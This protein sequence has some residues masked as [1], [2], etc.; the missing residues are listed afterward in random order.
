MEAGGS[1]FRNGRNVGDVMWAMGL[2]WEDTVGPMLDESEH[3]PVERA[4]ELVSV[5][6]ARPFTKEYLT[7]FYL[8]HMTGDTDPH[9][10]QR[11]AQRLLFGHVPAI[12][13]VSFEVWAPTVQ[14]KREMLLAILNKSIELNEPLLVLL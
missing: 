12:T 13:M 6:E 8:E 3:L 9:P 11:A 4:R 2:S 14:R 7:R 5:I 1:Y 10:L